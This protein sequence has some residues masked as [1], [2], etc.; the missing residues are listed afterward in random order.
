MTGLMLEERQDQE[1]GGAFAEFVAG[2]GENIS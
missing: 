1:F 2:H